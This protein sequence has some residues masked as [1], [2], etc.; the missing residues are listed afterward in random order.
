MIVLKKNE[1]RRIK[2]GGLWV[3][4]NEILE[5]RGNAQNGDLEDL[6]DSKGGYIGKG[7][8]NK[9]SLIALRLLTNK[10]NLDLRDLFQ[11][12]IQAAL[13]LRRRAYPERNSYRLLFSES[14]LMPG[15]IIDKYNDTFVLQV[16]S[17]GMEKNIGIIID[18]L[19][20]DLGAK[21]ILSKQDSYFRRLESLSEEDS[22][23]L[24]T[25]GEEIISD[26]RISYRVGFSDS[27]KT[28][29]YFD[30]SDNRFFI[31]KFCAGKSVLDCFCNIGGFGLHALSAGASKVTFLD[32]SSPAIN[33]VK[34]NLS[35]NE[36]NPEQEFIC[37][38]AFDA[39]GRLISSGR[40]F[41]LVV[42]DPPAFAKS[43]KNLPKAIKAY[44]KLNHLGIGLLNEGGMLFTASCSHH[45]TY[46][47]FIGAIGKA[48]SRSGKRLQ[49]FAS[50]GASMDHPCLPEMEETKYL[51]FAAF[52]DRGSL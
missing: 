35:L 13:S 7:F 50:N 11:E 43:K 12:R 20:E 8:Y 4:S 51:K 45:L 23:Y 49:L 40:K 41:D 44:E 48:C 22:L 10:Q 17:A 37:E 46:E 52:M 18:I 36:L 2:S 24:G 5:I 25:P 32:A 15:L 31:E 29:F 14:D 16:Y 6:Y 39:L 30:Q 21:C 9:G 28:G 19:R 33:A 47:D 42:L 3:F 34:E 38:D 27:Q 1:E 26:G